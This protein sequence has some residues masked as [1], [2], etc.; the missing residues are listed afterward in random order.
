VKE[1]ILRHFFGVD[2]FYAYEV[3]SRANVVLVKAQSRANV[4][5]NIFVFGVRLC[6][7]VITGAFFFTPPFFLASSC[8]SNVCIGSFKIKEKTTNDRQDKTTTTTKS[9]G[10][11]N[12]TKNKDTAE[13]RQRKN[14]K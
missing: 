5:V 7:L 2:G 6:C 10:K 8:G 1:Y 14:N 13:M 12:T 11:P 9:Q 3:Q 4:L